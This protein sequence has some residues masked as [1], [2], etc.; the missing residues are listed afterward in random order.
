MKAAIIQS[1]YLPWKGY[2]DIIH[3]VDTFVFLDDVQ[4]THRDWR[5]RNKIKTPGGT[6][7]ISVPVVG[8]INQLI[9]E[10]KIDYSQDWREKHKRMIH[11]CYASAPYYENYKSEI[12]EIFSKKFEFLSELNIYSIQKISEILDINTEFL[13]S[14]DIGM[15][16]TKDDKLI[17]ICQAIGADSYL[18]GPAAQNYIQEYKFINSNIELYYKDYSGYPDYSQRWGSFEHAVSII[19]LIFNCGERSTHYIWGWRNEE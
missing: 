15:T 16:G 4:Y 9:Y 8:G 2:F 11:H 3:D 14:K 7:W 10:V 19:D 17:S 1:N 12:F 5:N 18:S 6:K 13:H